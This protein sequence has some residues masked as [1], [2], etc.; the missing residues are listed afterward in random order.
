MVNSRLVAITSRSGSIPSSSIQSTATKE[1]VIQDQHWK[2][3]D[4]N[5]VEESESDRVERLGRER[6]QIFKSLWAEI[7]FCYSILASQIMAVS[8]L[9]YGRKHSSRSLKST[10]NL[11]CV[12][13]FRERLQ[14]H[15][16]HP[17]QK[18]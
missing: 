7:G 14:R 15:S 3:Q 16:S 2:N 17:G 5:G 13:V 12:G 18:A 10:A 8:D 4:Q 6:P 11:A 9:S 1:T